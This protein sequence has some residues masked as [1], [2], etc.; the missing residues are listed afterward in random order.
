LGWVVGAGIEHA[1]ANNWSL[2]AEYLYVRFDDLNANG[3]LTDSI[4]ADFANFSNHVDHFSSNIVRVG[5]NYRFSASPRST[6]Y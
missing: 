3:A 2:K 4:V 1:I 6:K 5:F